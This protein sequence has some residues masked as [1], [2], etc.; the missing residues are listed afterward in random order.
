MRCCNA[1]E[2]EGFI[3]I[4]PTFHD[5]LEG[6][7]GEGVEE[8]SYVKVPSNSSPEEIGQGVLLALSRCTEKGAIQPT[9]Q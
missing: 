8:S 4:E 7:S 6:F 5:K 3:T 1:D 9:K 2:H